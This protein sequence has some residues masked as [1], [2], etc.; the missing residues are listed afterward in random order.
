MKPSSPQSV[1]KSKPRT[2]CKVEFKSYAVVNDEGLKFNV[3]R[4]NITVGFYLDF[5]KEILFFS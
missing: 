1:Y 4:F 5:K 2:L 3:L